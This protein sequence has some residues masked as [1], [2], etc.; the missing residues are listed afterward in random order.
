MNRS[1]ES[2]ETYAFNQSCCFCN[3][4]FNCKFLFP[5]K[6]GFFL[7]ATNQ[8][9]FVFQALLASRAQLFEGRLA[10]N[11]GLILTLV[12]FSCAQKHFLGEFYLLFLELPIIN[13]Q[14]KRIKT[15]MLFK[16]S[17]LNLN[18]A[19]TLGYLNPALNNLVQYLLSLSLSFFF[20]NFLLIFSPKYLLDISDSLQSISLDKQESLQSTQ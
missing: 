18:I 16:L 15:E 9:I 14:T 12:S 1:K 20:C 10:L 4:Q 7:M 11:P 6:C 3:I 17:N 19:L 2:Q 8:A 5:L 13:L